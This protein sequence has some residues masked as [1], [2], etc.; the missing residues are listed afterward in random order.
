MR[1]LTSVSEDGSATRRYADLE[2]FPAGSPE[3]GLIN[4]LVVARLAV[5]DQ[6]GNRP[7]VCLA[8]EALLQSWPRV[9]AWLTK[10][11]T[12]LRLRDEL[13]RDARAWEAHGR[14]DGWLGTAPDKIATLE[15]VEREGLVPAG[16]AAEYARRS[17]GRARRNQHIRTAIV[18][19]ICLLS[20][21]SI[22]A[23]VIAVK[24]RN[25]AVAEATT[26]DRTSRFMVS[27][28]KLADPG[29]NR[30]NSVT[31]REV[32]DRGARDIER[33]M[34]NEPQVRANLL[35]A[36]GEAY[37]GLGLYEPAKPLLERARADQDAT[38]VP[39]ESKV[40]T[41]I[42]SGFLADEADELD[43][44][45]SFLQ[46]ALDLGQ[47]Q[48]PPGSV[49]ISDARDDLA[50]VLTQQKQYREAESL[51][52]AALTEDRKRGVQGS[53]TL[54]RTLDTLAQALAAE[55]RLAQAEAPT[56]EA[57]AIN[58]RYF[59]ERHMYTALSMN[60][61]AALYYQEGRYAQAAAEWQQALPVYREVFGAEHPEVATLLNNMGRSALMAGNVPEAIALF[62]Q[63]QQM[64]EKLWGPT[65]D[66][67]VLPLNSLGMAYLYQGDI[68]R[69]RTDI[70]RALQIARPRNHQI[71]D[72]VVLN[73]A[74]LALSTHDLKGAATSLEE[75][76]RLLAARYSPTD[77]NAQ[78]RYAVWDSV[79]AA[80]LAAEKRPEA[81]ALFARAREVLVKRYGPQSFF[82]LRL[83][84]RAAAP[85]E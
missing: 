16:I 50:D 79:D 62:E 24:Q 40:R 59:G 12:L 35:T 8:H 48:L 2:V 65:H 60:N 20:V 13:Q 43:S 9:G 63:A 39:A 49:L 82:V 22:V 56:R 64:G 69:A 41:L 72:Q 10:E 38:S 11:S 53:E 71:L 25:R 73:E 52:A 77:P 18:A 32:L 68:A 74:D 80:L 84:Q 81:R 31:V 3:R 37:T 78:W 58:Q 46:R 15:Q 47:A 26:A 83:D 75:A 66:Y 14:S 55:G 4:R 34:Q 29:E 6:H 17:R 1:E 42:A 36:M 19:S 85:I 51:C 57:L 27:L 21:V 30:G 61:L 23:A 5:T 28:F 70:D 45:K 44:A 54:A 7:V 67:L 33:G 76:R